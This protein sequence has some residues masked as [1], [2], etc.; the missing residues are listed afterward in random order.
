MDY[1]EINLA[2]EPIETPFRDLDENTN[3]YQ[4]ELLH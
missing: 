3:Y 1:L 2:K 4:P